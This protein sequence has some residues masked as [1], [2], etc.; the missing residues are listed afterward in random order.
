[1]D[2]AIGLPQVTSELTETFT[3]I[4]Q[5]SLNNSSSQATIDGI[6]VTENENGQLTT[7]LFTADNDSLLKGS[8]LL[9]NS[10]TSPVINRVKLTNSDRLPTTSN[11]ENFQTT[12]RNME[13][14]VDVSTINGQTASDVILPTQNL[15]GGTIPNTQT[16]EDVFT[17]LSETVQAVNTSPTTDNETLNVN[18]GSPTGS[19]DPQ[20]GD[21][22]T[23]DPQ[24][25][26]T[27]AI[28][29]TTLM[30]TQEVSTDSVTLDFTDVLNTSDV[31][32]YVTQ[33]LQA[34]SNGGLRTDDVPATGDATQESTGFAENEDTNT[35]GSSQTI[36]VVS[37]KETFLAANV[38]EF[39]F[40]LQTT[41]LSYTDEVTDLESSTSWTD[42]ESLPTADMSVPGSVYSKESLQTTIPSHAYGDEPQYF[43]ETISTNNDSFQTLYTSEINK[44]TS[45]LAKTTTTTTTGMWLSDVTS[46]TT[47]PAI[48]NL[49]D[50]NETELTWTMNAI[51]DSTEMSVETEVYTGS[52]SVPLSDIKER[53]NDGNQS[54]VGNFSVDPGMSTGISLGNTTGG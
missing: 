20:T 25:G 44:E 16:A 3:S 28:S 45:H 17:T 42:N 9:Q 7:E 13:T 53:S 2:G 46:A 26:D 1:M 43:N 36:T 38:S 8:M 54:T 30:M 40:T 14:L 24:T 4:L 49:E 47:Y 48:G 50:N 39:N 11:I 34:T 33:T 5:Y 52:S 18:Y 19:E 22:Q 29:D 23:G 27:V 31:F 6:V 35:Y 15:L 41:A 51:F 37:D 32:L 10:E 12:T 21:T